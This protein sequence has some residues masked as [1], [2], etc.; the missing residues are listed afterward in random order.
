MIDDDNARD[1]FA[2]DHDDESTHPMDE[3]TLVDPQDD[4]TLRRV[5]A[6]LS[7]LPAVSEADVQR[8][9]ARAGAGA[10]ESGR[11]GEHR[12]GASRPA[13]ASGE[14]RAAGD[15]AGVVAIHSRRRVW[16]LVP[17][18][19]AAGILVAAVIGVNV[20]RDGQ[21]G[22]SAAAVASAPGASTT[23]SGAAITSVGAT[24]GAEAPIATQF[25]L[26]APRAR[27]V[28][29]VGAFNQWDGNATP[30]VRDPATGLWS[31]TVPLAP[32][33]HVYA[34]MVDGATLTLDPRAPSAQDAELGTSVSVVLVGTP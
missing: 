4:E 1:R 31:A 27:Q 21:A 3:L 7:V 33:R 26:D 24:R 8:I 20:A 16:S 28:A 23:G 11:R 34:F 29:L 19:A 12:W 10:A 32:G 9:V 13:R 17:L 2:P 25:V 15:E 30:L 14:A 6:E 22:D 18:A 5:V